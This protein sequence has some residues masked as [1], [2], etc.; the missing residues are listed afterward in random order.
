MDIFDKQVKKH[1]SDKVDRLRKG[2][3]EKDPNHYK[4]QRHHWWAS[5]AAKATFIDLLEACCDM[6]DVASFFDNVCE[7]PLEETL[8]RD[9][10][11][12]KIVENTIHLLNPNITCKFFL[13]QNYEF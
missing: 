5:N 9:Q 11:F 7:V 3:V 8:Y 10:S 13:A 4:I 6:V 2:I 1:D 12:R